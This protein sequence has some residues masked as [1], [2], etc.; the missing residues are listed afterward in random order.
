MLNQK[1]KCASSISKGRTYNVLRTPEGIK[2]KLLGHLERDFEM[3]FKS[4]HSYPML[5]LVALSPKAF[6]QNFEI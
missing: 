2:L 5:F 6:N 3:W 4:H 1:A